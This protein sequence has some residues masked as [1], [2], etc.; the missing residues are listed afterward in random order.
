MNPK[1]KRITQN[2][3]PGFV[4]SLVA[5][6]LGLGLALASGVPPLA[7]LISAV[8]GGII[9]SILGGSNI[10]IVGPGNG[11]VA[12]TLAAVLTL[13][14]G[15]MEQ[16][17]LLALAAVVISGGI[18]LLM[19]MLKFGAL[20]DFFP[21][22]AVQG[23]LAAI[24]F[25]IMSKTLHLMLGAPDVQADSTIEYYFKLPATIH[26][27]QTGEIPWLAGILG[28][29]CLAIMILTSKIKWKLIKL[30]PA[31]MWIILLG[32]GTSYFSKMY[33]Q[34]L[35]PL[36]ESL[37]IQIPENVFEGM[38]F[39]DFS[40]LGDSQFWG[41]VISL[42]FIAGIESLLSLKAVDKLDALKRR[43]N[44]NKDLRA[45]G[46]A[47]IVSGFL[48]GLNVVTVI[49][50]SSINANYGATNRWSNFF[51]GAF[52]VIF[53]L[54]F[55]PA[56]QLI[57]LPA[58][59]SI[60]VYTGYKLAEPAGFVKVAKVGWQ[61]LLIFIVTMLGTLFAN[62]MIGIAAGIL[63]TLLFQFKAFGRIRLFIRYAF[64]PNTLLYEETPGVYL[65]SVK[66]FSSF[67]NFIGLKRKL[68]SVPPNSQVI[69][70]FSLA[71]FVDYSV[72]EQIS[73]YYQSFKNYGG[74]LEIIGL[75]DLGAYSAHPLAPRLAKADGAS[76]S[77]LSKRQK[78]IRLYAK[79]LAWE[80]K[81]QKDYLEEE[82]EPFAFFGTRII[83]S[84]RNRLTGKQGQVGVLMVDID[85]HE[86]EF[87]AQENRHATM[88]ILDLKQ[89][90][91]RF[92]LDKE[93]LLDKVAHL[94]GF[95]DIN[96]SMHPDFSENFKLKGQ[97]T[98]EL[99]QFF[100]NELIEFLQ[101]NKPFHIE[102]NGNAL[103]IF[104][105]ERLGTL[106]EIKQLVSFATR[107]AVILN[108]KHKK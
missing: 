83:D 1:I 107:L 34:Y 65:L 56:L 68:D 39:P 51:H 72:L 29:S 102:S 36:P 5:L 60:L 91:P 48:G 31:P 57:P 59:A 93:D 76:K 42:T 46:I 17:Y 43:S 98:P 20:S 62:L 26:Q 22:A 16:G 52:L 58:L 25:I 10:T 4:V 35:A 73:N 14:G 2:I 92:V 74:D 101:S 71:K 37:M 30:I 18:L 3:F 47:T 33:P 79:K 49:A 95:N 9:V 81:P 13:G 50:R 108:S 67:V 85:Y 53:V 94:A 32:I 24:G 77:T 61:Q 104:E 86:G 90:I 96:F 6:P 19:G 12:V 63:A 82:F 38:G 8:V 106:S 78:T 15:N 11:L 97:N 80:F 99:H 69:V 88:V 87:I 45:L 64:K 84:G 54:V 55:T 21:S 103:L 7:G 70:D 28:L 41:A 27:L 66:A 23:M 105:K 89:E 75:D 40:K 44:A 100:D